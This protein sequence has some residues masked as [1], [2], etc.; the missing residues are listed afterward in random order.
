MKILEFYFN[1]KTKGDRF[2]DTL[3]EEPKQSSLGNLYIIGELTNALPQ[4]AKFLTRTSTAIKEALTGQAWL[5]Q[6]F[7]LYVRHF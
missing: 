3:I 7:E 4:Q 5:K 1:P 2:F 6:Q